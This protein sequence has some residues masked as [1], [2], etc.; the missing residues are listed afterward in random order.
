MAF[1][2]IPEGFAIKDSE[3]IIA[4]MEDGERSAISAGINTQADSLLG[5]INGVVGDQVAE[6]WEV[7]GAV[8]RARQ[9]DSANGEALDNVSAITGTERLAATPSTAVANLNLDPAVTIVVG[10]LVGIGL[11]GAQ[12]KTLAEII[13]GGSDQTT[14]S[15]AVESSDDAPIVGNAN[16]IDTIVTPVAGWSGKAAFT[17]LTSEP[18]V[19]E[20]VQTLLVQVDEGSTQTVVF[21]TA[22]FVSIAA[23]TAQEVIDAIVADTTGIDGLDVSGFIRLFSDTDGT[24]SA[25]KIV[26]GSGFE[27]L[28]LSSEL[29]K[30]FNPSRA[31]KIV[32]G[33]SETYDMS[34]TPDLLVAVDG[35]SPQTITFADSD[36]GVA[37]IGN[38]VSIAASL[39]AV[40]VDTDTFI[41]DDGANPAVTF[42]FD[43]DSSVVET[44]TLRAIDHN[45]TQ[46]ASQMRDLAV[47]AINSAPTLDITASPSLENSNVLLANDLTG[48][49]GNVAIVET[50]ADAGFSV[51]GMAGGVADAPT[52]ATAVQVARKISSSLTGGIAYDV[53]GKV[54]IESDTVGINSALEITGGSSNTELGYTLSSIQI[55]T[56]GDAIVGRNE[57]SDEDLR[58]RRVQL[59]RNSGASTVE[60]IRA[61]LLD[62]IVT[63]GVEQAFVFENETDIIDGDG[64]PPHS[65]EAVVF[66]GTDEDIAQTLFDLKPIG[67]QTFKVVGPDGVSVVITDSQGTD[68]TINF[69]RADIITEHTIVDI[70]V[71]AAD[72]GGGDQVA[73]E[74]QVRT[75]I[76]ALGD[77][78]DVGE[79]IIILRFKCVPLEIAGVQDVTDIFIEDV[80]PPTNQANIVISQREL[81]TFITTNIDINVVFV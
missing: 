27:P 25:I 12:W 23:A 19:L 43:D 63:P 78:L 33:N 55:G 15:V 17:G 3:T 57:E 29:I 18:F 7:A 51:T 75:A 30:G 71:V 50:V 48:V 40:G 59:L 47:S 2:V 70:S 74:Q 6:L 22:D 76:K 4:E 21:N 26:G 77:T 5:Q 14:V 8:F 24:G 9:P 41:L 61:G 53:S 66:G 28:G 68:H 81:A 20:D 44:A 16:A 39:L 11:S 65:F 56:S 37:A 10:S 38:L 79:D 1:G 72:F 49:A 54:Q 58:L 34:G 52:V 31:A 69:S 35:G 80:E 36:F 73:G 13:N 45:G 60:A 67:I 64:R 62:P 42:A 46:T 32:N